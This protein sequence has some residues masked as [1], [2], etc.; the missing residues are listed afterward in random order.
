MSVQRYDLDACIGCKSCVT[1]CPMDVFRFDSD[2]MKSV[3]A[4]PENCQSC[5]Q[6]YLYCQ[7]DSLQIVNHT[8]AYGMAAMRATTTAYGPA[9]IREADAA[10]TAEA[11]ASSGS[12]SGSWNK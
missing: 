10:A 2:Q 1:I 12:N 4:Y 7:G 8:F 9:S 5:G 3:L 6:C 11:A